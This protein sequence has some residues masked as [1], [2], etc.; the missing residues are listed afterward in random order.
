[1]RINSQM[2]ANSMVSTLQANLSRM[3]KLNQQ[4]GGQTRLIVPSDDPIASTRMVQLNREQAAI[5]QYQSNI[6]RL[7]GNL[8]TQETQVNAVS[9]Q[10]LS[11]QDTLLAASN[12]THSAKDMEGYGQEIDSMIDSLVASMN[13]RNEDG[14]YVF[15][16]TKNDQPPVVYD[17]ES[18]QYI[19]QGNDGTRSTTVAN[20]VDIQEN[21]PLCQAFGDG[22]DPMALLNQLNDLSKKM[23]DP[24][25]NQ[26]DYQD[27]INR[28]LSN[29]KSTSDTISGLF[30]DLGGRQNRLTMLS[31]AH[32]DTAAANE[33]VMHDLSDLD[34][35]APVEFQQYYVASQAANKVYSMIADLSL[36]KVI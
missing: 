27:E 8:S 23:K 30:T 7:S 18:G 11:I 21:T 14:R 32:T 15:A 6:V 22:S 16:G 13:T 1:M 33:N 12:G 24:T 10:V 20:G 34:V 9:N 36:F 3:S 19:Y 35:G 31:D 26:A 2:M 5:T 29:V 17:E 4:I 28:A 25:Q